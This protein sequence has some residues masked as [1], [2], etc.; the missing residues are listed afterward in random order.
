MNNQTH[1]FFESLIKFVISCIL[2]VFLV[3]SAIFAK[4]GKSTTRNPVADFDGDG[5]SDISV[6]RP[7]NGFWYVMKSSGGFSSVQFGSK[8]DFPVP[9]D[10]DGDGKTDIAVHRFGDWMSYNG[11]ENNYWY[12]L[13]SSDNTLQS[14]LFGINVGFVGDIPRP[15]DYD[16]D[17]KTDVASYRFSDY[18]LDPVYFN[19]V[20]S[21]SNSKLNK[22]WGISSDTIIPA[23]YDGDGK[24]DLA[25]F[26]YAYNGSIS[27]GIWFILQSSDGKMR[28]ERFGLPY[29][30][31]VPADYDG[32]GK[33]DIAVWRPSNGFWYYIKSSDGAFNGSFASVQFGASGDKPVPADYDGDGRTDIAVFRPS[34][35]VWYLLQS[36]KGFAAQQF[37]FGDDVPIPN[38]FVR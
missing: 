35:G 32:D 3:S 5:K 26:R 2:L 37:G 6:F 38:V 34:N 31:F 14:I 27:E 11:G 13:K 1:S 8:D 30:K 15:A 4:D 33:D 29:D 24:T 25:V 18:Q 17:G 36:T 19:I 22:Y 28:V 12:I 7:S 23:D 16:G 21:S 20:Q 9:G 10:Y